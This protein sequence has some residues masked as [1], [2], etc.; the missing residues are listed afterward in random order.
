ML[1]S[2]SIYHHKCYFEMAKKG[3]AMLHGSGSGHLFLQRGVSS[4]Q[5]YFDAF[6]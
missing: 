5:E 2:I 4:L 3:L 1:K 6:C